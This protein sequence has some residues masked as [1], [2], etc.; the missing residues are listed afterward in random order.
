MYVV[1]TILMY[2]KHDKIIRTCELKLNVG[3]V[4]DI[5]ARHLTI[6]HSQVTFSLSGNNTL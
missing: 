1:N 6:I 3:I 2:N 4:I 5:P